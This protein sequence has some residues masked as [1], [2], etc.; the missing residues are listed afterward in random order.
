MK[1]LDELR[2]VFTSE[3]MGRTIAGARVYPERAHPQW[4]EELP[5]IGVYARRMTSD[6]WGEEGSLGRHVRRC[7]L[8]LV[9]ELF[10]RENGGQI[11]EDAAGVL[12][13][14]TTQLVDRLL[15]DPE[16]LPTLPDLRL[17]AEET[18]LEEVRWDFDGDGREI[19]GG[20]E[21]TYRVV[22]LETVPA[23][24]ELEE[25][26]EGKLAALTWKVGTL[27][28]A[29]ADSIDLDIQPS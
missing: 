19:L 10:V 16:P 12:V 24:D 22:Y 23:T 6:R 11:A 15:H 1:T 27:A 4:R 20:V 5:A 28:E 13:R 7:R 29:A 21:V 14:Q 8:E 18:G 26:D 2:S 25:L 9:L 3:L 17:L